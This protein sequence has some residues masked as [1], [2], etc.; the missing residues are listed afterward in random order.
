M[1]IPSRKS[2]TTL[3]CNVTNIIEI[4][5]HIL[6]T[7]QAWKPSYEDNSPCVSQLLLSPENIWCLGEIS[8]AYRKGKKLLFVIPTFQFVHSPFWETRKQFTG[9]GKRLKRIS[10]FLSNYIYIYIYIYIL[11]FQIISVKEIKVLCKQCFRDFIWN[12]SNCCVKFLKFSNSE[13]LKNWNPPPWA[14]Q[15]AHERFTTVDNSIFIIFEDKFESFPKCLKLK[16]ENLTKILKVII[17]SKEFY[18]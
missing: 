8:P 18:L 10:D 12:K 17:S 4:S 2:R 1:S 9:G 7:F 15:G 11:I 13:N 16:R 3:Y 6:A 14:V 5:L